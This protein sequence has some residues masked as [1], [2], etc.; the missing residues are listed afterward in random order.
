MTTIEYRKLLRVDYTMK[1]TYKTKRQPVLEGVGLSKNI[2]A[3][4]IQIITDQCLECDTTLELHMD[5]PGHGQLLC[6]TGVVIWHKECRYLPQSQRVHYLVRIK[7]TSAAAK[8]VIVMTDFITKLLQQR[9]E[10]KNKEIIDQF[11][12]MKNK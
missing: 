5:F 6:F 7:F 11:E 1:V 3:T 10:G 4:G 2:S 12:K 9:A 8:E